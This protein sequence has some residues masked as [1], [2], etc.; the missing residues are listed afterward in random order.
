LFDMP[1]IGTSKSKPHQNQ[2]LPVLSDSEVRERGR[3]DMM[4]TSE[5]EHRA[6]LQLSAVSHSEGGSLQ[7]A[8]VWHGL[9]GGSHERIS[10]EFDHLL[11]R[12]VMRSELVRVQ[13]LIVVTAALA[14]VVTLVHIFEPAL[15][16]QVWRGGVSPN[17][18]YPILV[19]F[20]LFEFWIYRVISHAVGG[21][22]QGIQLAASDLL[23]RPRCAG[24]GRSRR[25]LARRGTDQGL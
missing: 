9:V 12:E 5:S 2:K 19:G 17:S 10:K 15:V 7:I 16:Q 13:S 18:I 14:S 21:V 4:R 25:R 8:D 22:E 11:M 3:R 20:T 23:E 1:V 6:R 24:R